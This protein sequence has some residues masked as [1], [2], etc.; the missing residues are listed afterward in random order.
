MQSQNIIRVNARKQ[1]A[2]IRHLLFAYLVFLLASCGMHWTF[3]DTDTFSLFISILFMFKA[4]IEDDK[5]VE[6]EQLQSV[7]TNSHE[8]AF[9][10]KR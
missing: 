2:D 3:I 6:H 1:K 9:E 10:W 7:S 5:I 8:S 4:Y